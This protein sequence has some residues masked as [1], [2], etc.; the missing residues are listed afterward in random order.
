MFPHHR[1]AYLRHELSSLQ[2][3]VRKR[4]D[5]RPLR[6]PFDDVELQISAQLPDD[7][8]LG[9]FRSTAT[10]VILTGSCSG[11]KPTCGANAK[12]TCR[13]PCPRLLTCAARKVIVAAKQPRCRG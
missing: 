8:R 6:Q 2:R 4:L 7:P 9:C 3:L 5:T 13:L 12:R 1:V 11:G 10:T